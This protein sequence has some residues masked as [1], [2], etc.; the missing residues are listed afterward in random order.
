MSLH[1][2]AQSGIQNLYLAGGVI[3]RTT[4]YGEGVSFLDMKG[5]LRA[6]AIARAEIDAPLSGQEVKF[7]RHEIGFTQAM[8]GEFLEVSEQTIANWEKNKVAP[9]RRDCLAI[10]TL[11][12]QKLDPKASIDQL[13][14]KPMPDKLVLCYSE[15]YGWRVQELQATEVILISRAGIG[16]SYVTSG[17]EFFT[18]SKKTNEVRNQFDACQSAAA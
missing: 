15:A 13:A 3:H 16:S 10:Q 6:A 9:R 18:Y 2:F 1:H 7:L 4:P 14:S 12:L 17:E 8:L 5:L 11:A